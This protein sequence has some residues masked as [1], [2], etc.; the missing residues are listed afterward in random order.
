MND[1]VACEEVIGKALRCYADLEM[2]SSQTLAVLSNNLAGL[3]VAQGRFIESLDISSEL[4]SAPEN[5]SFVRH[6]QFLYQLAATLDALIKYKDATMY[7]Q[8]A[9]TLFL[10]Y[11][12]SAYVKQTRYALSKSLRRGGSP[13]LA[14][15]LLDEAHR[16]Q[17]VGDHDWTGDKEYYEGLDAFDHND[18]L[19]ARR[20]FSAA[21]LNPT[22]NGDI[23]V[24]SSHA[25]LLEIDRREDLLTLEKVQ[26]FVERLDAFGQDSILY[27]DAEPKRPLYRECVARG[28]FAERFAPF[29]EPLPSNQV[30]PKRFVL[31]VETLGGFHCSL[32]QNTLKFPFAKAAELLV[33]LTLYGPA[34][35]DDAL[36]DGSSDPK[37]VEYAK[38]ALRRLRTSLAEHVSFNP[39]VYAE[40]EYQLA[41]E[42]EV[43]LDI[44][45]LLKAFEVGNQT[46]RYKALEQYR[47]TFLPGIRL[48]TKSL[49]KVVRMH[50]RKFTCTAAY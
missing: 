7:Y 37:H 15:Q 48:C 30:T 16:E 35:R 24:I 49:Q 20:N 14:R 32:E 21:L 40:H 10:K 28:W 42:L 23:D 2:S 3:Y 43:K 26:E 46:T 19:K 31:E 41:N 9:L 34:S 38:L 44:R 17:A 29:T 45:D 25:Y 12:L 4:L 47:G 1:Y 13:K 50:F 36:W 33:W 11:S 39:L 22:L 18:M 5:R 8:K 27:N 6:P